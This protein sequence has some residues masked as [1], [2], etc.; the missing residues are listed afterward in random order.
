MHHT[1]PTDMELG[2][3]RSENSKID[4]LDKAHDNVLDLLDDSDVFEMQ[5][6]FQRF[7]KSTHIYTFIQPLM[8]RMIGRGARSH[9]RQCLEDDSDRKTHGKVVSTN[10]PW[11]LRLC[12]WSGKS[13]DNIDRL[14]ESSQVNVAC[15]TPQLSTVKNYIHYS[16][17][18]FMHTPSPQA[19]SETFRYKFR[20][21]LLGDVI[22]GVT[23]GVMAVPQGL[24]YSVIVGLPPIYGLYSSLVPILLFSMLGTSRET[25]VGPF[26]ELVVDEMY[27][28]YMMT[29]TTRHEIV[30]LCGSATLISVFSWDF[31]ATVA[32]RKSA[33]ITKNHTFHV[34][35]LK[36]CWDSLGPRCSHTVI[37]I[38]H[39]RNAKQ[40]TIFHNIFRTY[41][42]WW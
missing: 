19:W 1:S 28:M 10:R 15:T 13:S 30:I 4:R 32:S 39:R 42:D 2:G 12:G 40:R 31:A 29:L 27:T 26:G 17:V 18:T 34:A 3:Q 7:Q 21:T 36:S 25:A 38:K 23:V 37:C 6:C 11:H 24:A 41:R 9:L 35:S 5:G 14:K 33:N 20:E 8:V 22:A 16:F